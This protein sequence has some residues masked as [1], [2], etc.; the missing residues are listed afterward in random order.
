MLLRDLAPASRPRRATAGSGRQGVWPAAALT[1]LAILAL[2]MA[3][4]RDGPTLANGTS[5]QVRVPAPSGVTPGPSRSVDGAPIGYA[6]T[7]QGAVSA[8]VQ[9]A[10]AL[11]G[12]GLLD[13]ERRATILRHVASDGDRARLEATL[14]DG[15]SL[16]RSRLGLDER[17][18]AD[19]AFVWRPVPAGW[20]L[21][22]HDPAASTVDVWA[23]GVVSIPDR[24]PI[25]I[26]WHTTRVELLWVGGDWKLASFATTDGPT[27]PQGRPDVG[28][29]GRAM[30][31]FEPLWYQPA[32]VA[33]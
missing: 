6:H 26:G 9:Y 4:T 17:T 5:P 8:A 21:V 33:P 13:D 10:V 14:S 24:A 22:T 3:M 25:E 23:T 11:D 20:R 29:A 19:P 2:G 16:L 32:E 18:L 28:T 15:A 1:L 7:A 30:N 27:P 31:R 12:I